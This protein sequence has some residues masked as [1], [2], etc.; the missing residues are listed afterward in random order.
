MACCYLLM[1]PGLCST[2]HLQRREH[3]RVPRRP[4][5][6]TVV[7]EARGGAERDVH[8]V[9]RRHGRT[10]GRGRQASCG[11]RAGCRRQ[12]AEGAQGNRCGGAQGSVA[13]AEQALTGRPASWKPHNAKIDR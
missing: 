9:H 5:A 7:C 13:S 11:R 10:S 12:A 3:L 6:G 2:A 8:P 1:R 4:A